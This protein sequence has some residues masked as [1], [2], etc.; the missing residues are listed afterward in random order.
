MQPLIAAVY[1]LNTNNYRYF[2]MMDS[3]FCSGHIRLIDETVLIIGGDNVGVEPGFGDGRY[4]VRVFTPG[5]RPN[6]VTTDIMQPY[7]SPAIDPNSGARWYPTLLTMIDGNVL[8]AS[9][10]T[11]DGTAPLLPCLLCAE[12]IRLAF[13]NA[14]PPG[15][16]PFCLLLLKLCS[17]ACKHVLYFH[18]CKEELLVSCRWCD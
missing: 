14:S 15:I 18:H 1:N 7:F 12:C 5:A 9:G 13:G 10:A 8:I 4:S 16:L 6:Y 11:T 2:P 3:P 17:E